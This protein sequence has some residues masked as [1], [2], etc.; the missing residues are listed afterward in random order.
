MALRCWVKKSSTLI[1][2]R[3]L[4][5]PGAA[6][7]WGPQSPRVG[8]WGSWG[9]GPTP[10]SLYPAAAAGAQEAGGHSWALICASRGVSVARLT[11]EGQMKV[12][13]SLPRPPEV[14]EGCLPYACWRLTPPTGAPQGVFTAPGYPCI[15]NLNRR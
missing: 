7:C 11:G 3:W 1:L 13:V 15:S 4:L 12:Q 14:H 6:T 8:S 9:S 2:L 5:E 10:Y